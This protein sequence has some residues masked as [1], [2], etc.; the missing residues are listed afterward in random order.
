MYDHNDKCKDF[1][2]TCGN[3]WFV[4]LKKPNNIPILWRH[5]TQTS[6]FSALLALCAGNS[7]VTGEF[8]SARPVTRSFHVFF[9]LRLNKR[10]TKHSW[11]W[12]FETPSRSLWR[13]CNKA[14]NTGVR[15]RDVTIRTLTL[16]M[17]WIGIWIDRGI[18]CNSLNTI[19]LTWR[20]AIPHARRCISKLNQP[21]LKIRLYPFIWH[22]LFASEQINVI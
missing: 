4:P 13:H 14:N 18:Y 11:G 12:W 2:R 20:Y 8:P 19:K 17:Y 21:G 5:Q 7:P 16:Y 9:D 10:L 6:I 15:Q 1:I 3:G 22:F